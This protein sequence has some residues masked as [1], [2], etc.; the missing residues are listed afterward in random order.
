M[1]KIDRVQ[2]VSVDLLKPYE[3]N[4]KVHSEEQVQKIADSI[5]EFGFI[6]PC[7]IDKENRII[8]GHGRVMAAKIHGLKKVPCVYVEGLTDAQRRAYILADNRLTEL[9]EWNHELVSD[10]LVRLKEEGFD[11]DLTGFDI[12]DIIFDEI[13]DILPEPDPEELE[14]REPRVHRGEVW[15]LG[16]H[17]LM[18]GDST[19]PQDVKIL[20]GGGLFRSVYYGPTV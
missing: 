15:V 4:A 18:C 7:L 14:K 20:A 12:D 13:E 16:D 11:I 1:A 8:A 10:E 19:S 6:S 17:R 9:G 3:N 5:K 2:E